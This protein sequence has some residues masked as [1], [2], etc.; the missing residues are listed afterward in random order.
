MMTA[1]L[2]WFRYPGLSHA[3][4]WSAVTV[5]SALLQQLM[6]RG[7]FIGVGGRLVTLLGGES[8]DGVCI[9][10][11]SAMGKT[12]GVCLLLRLRA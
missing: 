5:Y 11:Q 12:I 3:A 2:R 1:D 6:L 7:D 8:V 4:S 10:L 9:R